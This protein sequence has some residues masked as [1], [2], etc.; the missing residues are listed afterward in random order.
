M[1]QQ[2]RKQRAVAAGG[3]RW[4]TLCSPPPCR[5]AKRQTARSLKRAAR[6]RDRR[7]FERRQGAEAGSLTY[8]CVP[9]NLCRLRRQERARG[10]VAR[11]TE[12]VV[13][14]L[15]QELKRIL[16]S[17]HI[18]ADLEKVGCRSKAIIDARTAASAACRQRHAWWHGCC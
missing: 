14:R 5:A 3:E 15:M 17:K 6:V 16:A 7:G 13:E 2:R 18:P 10:E 11:D 8:T 12:Y 1:Q 9:P 4:R